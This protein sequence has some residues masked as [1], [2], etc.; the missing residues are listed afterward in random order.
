MTPPG[1]AD[2]TIRELAVEEFPLI[3]PLIEKHNAKIAPEE[4]HRRLQAM[5]PKG[6]HCIAAFRGDAVVGVA[7]YWLLHRFYSG[8][9]MDVDNVVV[10][11]TAR[12]GGIGAAM[13]AW[14][15]AKARELGCN[16]VMLD[17]YVTLARAHR[18][19]FRL[20][21]EILGYHFYKAL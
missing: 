8:E 19:Y 15:E 14:L 4:L 12:S 17:S 3:L 7:G 10:E 20:G 6:Y 9:Y 18:F 13:M 16:A 11:E 5:I 21:Y 1:A 2:L